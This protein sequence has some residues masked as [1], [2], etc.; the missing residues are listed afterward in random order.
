[1]SHHTS[2]LAVVALA[3]ILVIPLSAAAG[4][5]GSRVGAA[6]DVV[7]AKAEQSPNESAGDGIPNNSQDV[8]YGSY[9]AGESPNESSGDGIPNA[10]QDANQGAFGTSSGSE[11]MRE[12]Q[13]PPQGTTSPQVQGGMQTQNQ[14]GYQVGQRALTSAELEGT[15]ETVRVQVREEKDAEEGAR[16]IVHAN[17]EQAEVALRTMVAAG[18][19][20]GST[21]PQ[22][23]QLT[24][25]ITE[26]NTKALDAEVRTQE[27]SSIVRFFAGGDNEAADEIQQY[28]SQN[29][30]TAREMLQLVETCT[31]CDDAAR[32]TLR[33][34][35]R[36]IDAEQERMLTLATRERE[37]KGL[38]GF[39]F[40]WFL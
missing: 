6:N 33:E 5:P 18:P 38:F 3:V 12:G 7:P 22:M 23:L 13:Y 40:G 32:N 26:R 10:S 9:G 20:F 37:S 30:E 17:R 36:A 19:L 35:V 8:E 21:S 24:A 29:R 1:M 2:T 31:T 39:L 4:K 16:G 11:R 14:Y 34:Q 28:A 15:L 27:R 25:R